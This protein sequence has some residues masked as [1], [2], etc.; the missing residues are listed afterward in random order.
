[1][2]PWSATT[3]T[4]MKARRLSKKRMRFFSSAI[5]GAT[6]KN[7]QDA[8][9]ARCRVRTC[10]TSTDYQA[11]AE[12]GTQKGTQTF[13][14][15]FEVC[16]VLAI[17]PDLPEALKAAVLAIIRTHKRDLS[18]NRGSDRRERSEG[19]ASLSRE[20][21]SSDAGAKPE[22]PVCGQVGQ[23]AQI[24]STRNESES[25]LSQGLENNSR[26]ITGGQSI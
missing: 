7:R 14:E 21:K 9:G 2:D 3:Q 8:D 18:I 25:A 13:R 24:V 19:C 10:N 4:M 5:Q 20:A 16:E 22:Q 6:A 26:N 15:G 17:W 23:A 12:V 11:L 1:M